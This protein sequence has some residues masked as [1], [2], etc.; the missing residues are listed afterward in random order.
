MNALVLS[1]TAIVGVGVGAVIWWFGRSVFAAISAAA[2][3][4]AL[5]ALALPWDLAPANQQTSTPRASKPRTA[6][7][8]LPPVPQRPTLAMLESARPIEVAADGYLGSE[9]CRECHPDNHASWHASYHRTMTQVA[10]PDV[11]LG[12]FEDVN[13]SALGRDY[14]LQQHGDV[15]WVDMHD[16]ALPVSPRSRVNAPI[17]MTTG[18]HHMQAYWYATGTGRVIGL[19]PI[20]H[21]IETNE[22]I[23]RAAA[24]LQPEVKELPEEVARWNLVCSQ[25]HT[26]HRRERPRPGTAELWDTQV[27]EFGI[28]CEA[29][30]GPGEHHIEY[31]RKVASDGTL[32]PIVNPAEL[33]HVRSSQVCGQCHA[34]Q[35][36]IQE[37]RVFREHGHG[38]RPGNDL[39]E[40][41]SIWERDGMREYLRTHAPDM[42]PEYM[43]STVYYRDGVVRVS[44]REYNGLKDSACYSRGTM[45]CLSCHK[46]HKS[47]SDPRSLSQW[48][49][50]QLKGAEAYGDSTCLQC[51]QQ[52][53]YSTAHTHHQAGSLGSRCY[54]CHMPHTTYGLL[55]AIRSHTI[56]SP[57][58]G[59]DLSARRPNAC[60]LCHLDQTLDWTAEH[61]QSWYGID[62]PQLDDDERNIAASILWTLKGDAAERALV[63]WSMGW[64]DALATSGSDWQLPFLSQLLRDDY[65]AIR[66]IA[67][68]SIQALPGFANFEFDNLAPESTRA[69]EIEEI[70]RQWQE[71][72][73]SHQPSR[74]QLL[75]QDNQV[76]VDTATRLLGERDNTPIELAE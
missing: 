56:S 55:K 46:M 37:E 53:E 10:S 44:G 25:C 60:N 41:H 13:V 66:F 39:N 2:A 1:L 22:W 62:R 23:P 20:V 33:S 51:H 74:P 47:E 21:L 43:M 9:S 58:V 18:S 45:S 52:E 3:L 67:R 38:F 35:T 72:F 73:E 34:V 68:R 49:D 27:A 57:D 76:L 14:R 50:D 48:A 6:S 75:I 24:F 29:C 16:P 31:Q 42:D 8:L 4:I 15:C 7:P 28:S 71:R 26:T 63:A 30:H 17:V 40:T 59:K 70:Q 19:L 65:I 61:L 54:N 11:V 69:M 36:T 12:D 5:V 32:D 64:A